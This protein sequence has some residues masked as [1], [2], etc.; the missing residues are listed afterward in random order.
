MG[1][2]RFD[3]VFVDFHFHDRPRGRSVRGD[4]N[5]VFSCERER[6]LHGGYRGL[7]LD[8]YGDAHA[9]SGIIVT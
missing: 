4:D 8:L 5:V 9:L 2:K 3:L 1:A 7:V 6:T